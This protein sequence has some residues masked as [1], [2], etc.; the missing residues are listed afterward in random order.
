[1]RRQFE[2]LARQ[3]RDFADKI[4]RIEKSRSSTIQVT[5]RK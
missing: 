2:F 3:M 1:M 4:E 5:T